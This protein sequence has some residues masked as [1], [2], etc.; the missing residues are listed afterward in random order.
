MLGLYFILNVQWFKANGCYNGNGIIMKITLLST[1]ALARYVSIY[2]YNLIKDSSQFL[3]VNYLY[4]V[5]LPNWDYMQCRDKNKIKVVCLSNGVYELPFH[6][7]QI[8]LTIQYVKDRVLLCNKKDLMHEVIL[9]SA[10]EDALLKFVEEA[11]KTVEDLLNQ[12]GNTMDTT[13][14]KYIYDASV[15]YPEWELINIAKKRDTS[16]LFL[17]TNVKQRIFDYINYFI[18]DEARKEYEDYGIP[19]KCNLLLSGVPGSGKTS[20]IHCI[21]SLINSDIGILPFTRCMDD[22][23]FTKAI[24]GMGRLDNCR[25][26]VLE[27]I[28]SLFSDDRKQHDSSKNSIT[29]SGILNCLDGLCRNEGIIVCITTNRKEV[30]DEAILRSGRMDMDVEFEYIKQEQIEEMLRF[31]YKEAIPIEAFYDKIQHYQLTTSDFQQFLFRYRHTPKEIMKKY[32]ELQKKS[33]A[34]NTNA[35][36]YS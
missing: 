26:L 1:N 18:K 36:L 20:T 15:N 9:E 19:Y 32:K 35:K 28:D 5:T 13:I 29:M 14:R 34:A 31:Y 3:N 23:K 10:N 2:A 16:T 21:A 17:P 4:D 24:N 7:V 27:D 33:G 22:I 25:V 6:D 11:K 8:A 30:L 12:E